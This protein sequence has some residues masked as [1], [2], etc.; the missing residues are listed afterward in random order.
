M[1][2]RTEAPPGASLR[3]SFFRNALDPRPTEWEGPWEHLVNSLQ[4]DRQ[5]E[6]LPGHEVKLGLP[7]LCGATFAPGTTRAREHAVALQL[8]I[9]DVDNA[10]MVPSGETHPSGRPVLVKA[11][12]ERPAQLGG[13][14]ANLEALGLAAFGWSTWSSAPG[15]PRF[16]VVI[17]LVAP[18]PADLWPQAVEW[19]LTRTGLNAWREALDLPVLRDTA[20][21]NFLPARR[22]G[23]PVVERR[24][25]TGAPLAVPLEGLERIPVP[26]P[27]LQTWQR[28]HLAR[29]GGEGY[30]WANRFRAADGS[31]LDLRTLDAVRLLES[32]GC[33]IGPG[34]SWG[35]GVKHRTTCPWP[36]EHSHGLDDDCA[37]LFME[38]GRW[39]FWRC[40][41]SHHAHLGLPDLLESAGVLR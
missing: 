19:I 9:L 23:G 38:T 37:V 41:H 20:R 29:R 2:T 40:A 33:R 36:G 1:E 26:A 30:G 35:A 5:P 12:L 25:A 39:P 32:L 18:V 8:V 13:M 7:A 11:P 3:C 28:D 4:R 10:R 31:P 34:R 14:T 24:E 16:R 21:L 15:W 27:A 6:E 22:P 17:P